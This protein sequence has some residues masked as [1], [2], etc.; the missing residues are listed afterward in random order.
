MSVH[1]PLTYPYSFV[2]TYLYITVPD[3]GAG[4]SL[5][6]FNFFVSFSQFNDKWLYNVRLIAIYSLE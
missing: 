4:S 2:P 3:L 5:T 1:L 6:Y